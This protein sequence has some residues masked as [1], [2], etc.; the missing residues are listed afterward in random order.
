MKLALSQVTPTDGDVTAALAHVQATLAMAACAGADMLIL[1]ELYLPGY[2]RPDL[3][4]DLAQPFDGVWINNL[5]EMAQAAGCGVTL[6]WAE[7]AGQAV[8]NA[9]TAIGPDGQILAHYRKIQLFGPMERA[10][11]A[12]GSEPPPVFDLGG[13]R[14]GLMIC[15]D[16]EFPHHTSDLARRGAEV[17]LVPTA[18]PKGYEHVQRVLVPARAYETRTCVVYANYCGTEQGLA[19]GGESLMAGPDSRALVSAGTRPA[20]LVAEIPALGDYA[21]EGLS[22]MDQDFRPGLGG[23]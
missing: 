11:F 1:P 20:L 15:Y 5:Q 23:A 12:F 21:P 7:R 3:H 22:A 9:A 19:F 17:I 14:C 10:S 6:G 2:N 13:R 18:N 8:F 16:V 4:G